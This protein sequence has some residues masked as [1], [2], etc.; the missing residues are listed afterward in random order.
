MKYLII[1]IFIISSNSTQAQGILKSYFYKSKIA[2]GNIPVPGGRHSTPNTGQA[3]NEIVL[4][5]NFNYYLHITTTSKQLPNITSVVVEGTPYTFRIERPV[6]TPIIY[7]YYDGT[8]RGNKTYTLVPKTTDY[9]YTITLENEIEQP[10]KVHAS[11]SIIVAYTNDKKVK[12]TV[13]STCKL[14]PT[15][16]VY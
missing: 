15:S 12:Q 3:T 1:A 16:V 14:L 7:E 9:V 6:A 10:K 5:E 2:M 4:K 11:T 8:K 13:K